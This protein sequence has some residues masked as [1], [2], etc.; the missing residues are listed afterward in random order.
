MKNLKSVLHGLIIA[1]G[2]T[3]IILLSFVLNRPPAVVPADAPANVFSAQ[4]AA[5]H[6]PFIASHPNPIGSK[7]NE[8]VRHY[9]VNYLENL[10]LDVH[11][12]KTSYYHAPAQRAATLHNVLTRIPGTGS[13]KAIL[14]MGHYDTVVNAPGASDNGAAVITMLEL[15]RMLLH[16][17]P[18]K[19][20]LIFF[21]P[22]GEE[23]GLLGARAFM[24]D[25]PW[26]SDI[27]M[28]IN[29]EAMGT[30]GQSLMFE[31][32]KNNL[33]TVKEYAR[34]V[35]FPTGNSLSK[36]IYK[37]MPTTTDFEVFKTRGFQGLNFAYIGSSYD[38]HTAGDNIENTDL[39]SIQ[40]HGE[41]AAALALHFGNLDPDFDSNRDT[42]YFNTIGYGFAYYP[43]N[44]VPPIAI[45]IALII[46]GI[47]ITAFTKK[48]I[49]PLH[50]L[51]AGIAFLFKLMIIYLGTNSLYHIIESY[52]ANN[53]L[54]LLQYNQ[55][56]I[57]AGFVFLVAAFS[58]LYDQLLVKGVKISQMI[59]IYL[60]LMVL[61]IWGGQ[62]TWQIAV[63]A[64]AIPLHLFFAHRKPID[65]H[66]L[67]SGAIVI[68]TLIML[69][70]SFTVTG[71]SYLFKW[72]LLIGVVPFL[73]L[74][75]IRKLKED[76]IR[77]SLLLVICAIPLL[78]WFPYLMY[79]FQLAMG[80]SFIGFN[81]VVAGL[82][83]GLLIPHVFAIYRI[84]KWMLPAALGMVGVILLVSFSAGLDYTERYRKQNRI[85][86]ATDGNS[87]QSFWLSFDDR[88]DEWTVQ[89]IGES[90]DDIAL[91]P[92]YPYHTGVAQGNI[93]PGF[94]PV[95]PMLKV[96][97][98]T[99]S[100]GKRKLSLQIVANTDA[101]FLDFYFLTENGGTLDMGV[102]Q[103]ARSRL[104]PFRDSDWMRFMYLA[105]PDEGIIL[106]L[107]TGAGEAIH[108]HLNELNYSGI[109]ENTEYIKRPAH[110]MNAGDLTLISHSYVF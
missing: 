89:F 29:F 109:P 31:T 17:P 30:S 77:M 45:I 99:I 39:R 59:S 47:L 32:G 79:L 26:I 106:H 21:F 81:M 100:H 43:Y 80:L 38:Y 65:S 50:V 62:F 8:A 4:R 51:F 44:A 60:L 5:V 37:M 33:K 88:P 13:G 78:L 82:M 86:H 34:A 22:D 19:N 101:Y 10:D 58:V 64:L 104:R 11:V 1:I 49:K 54:K 83:M 69:A 25:H 28:V 91:A 18:L 61:L 7:A 27:E 74:L 6:L 110:M 71:A 92:F 87:G 12:Q 108:I 97:S 53:D 105:P 66:S 75:L 41:H 55:N 46:L 14:F 36:E 48:K 90:P 3:A 84:N 24:R 107:Y 85:I 35:P 72:P 68:W 94:D 23:Y 67:A 56:G 42:V 70:V 40:H 16:N 93:A 57:L 2:I 15:V 102:G 95:P 9:I 96:L 103:S 73:L 63:V 20:D 52:Y 98:D 76:S